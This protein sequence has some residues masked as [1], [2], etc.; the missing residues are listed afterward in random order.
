VWLEVKVLAWRPAALNGWRNV[1]DLRTSMAKAT[2]K[3]TEVLKRHDLDL[4]EDFSDVDGDLTNEFQLRGDEKSSERH[5]VWIHNDPETIREYRDSVLGYEPVVD[6]TGATM[7]RRDHVLYSC[8]Q[9]KF[10]KKERFNKITYLKD[11]AKFN[12][13][14]QRDLRVLAGDDR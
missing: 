9:E 5:E 11:M 12:K 4:N 10:L 6:A 8:D 1:A 14:A 7:T 3:A 2:Q 13:K